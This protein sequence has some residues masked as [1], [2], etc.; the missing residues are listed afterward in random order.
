MNPGAAYIASASA[1]ATF[2]PEISPEERLMEMRCCSMVGWRIVAMFKSNQ[3]VVWSRQAK[4]PYQGCWGSI[5]GLGIDDEQKKLLSQTATLSKPA[6]AWWQ[7]R[8]SGHG[9][10]TRLRIN[11]PADG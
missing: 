9:G 10:T 7:R 3:G 4:A 5:V 8:V 1:D 11:R 2:S 6:V